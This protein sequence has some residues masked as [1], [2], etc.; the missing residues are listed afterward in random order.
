[1]DLL[2]NLLSLMNYNICWVFF[3]SNKEKDTDC[4]NFGVIYLK[5]SEKQYVNSIS[6]NLDVIVSIPEENQISGRT[7]I[8]KCDQLNLINY[9]EEVN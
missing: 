5:P 3:D 7:E 6:N 4:K 8:L 2:N 9:L 1:M